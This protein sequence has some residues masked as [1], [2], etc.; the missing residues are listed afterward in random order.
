MDWQ[1]S[2]S[3][4]T[5]VWFRLMTNVVISLAEDSVGSVQQSILGVFCIVTAFLLG[6]YMR[7]HP[8]PDSL[9]KNRRQ[10]TA[11]T[12]APAFAFSSTTPTDKTQVA[13]TAP[14]LPAP[15]AGFT[16]TAP[17]VAKQ[18]AAR[19]LTTNTF[20]P[21]ESTVQAER[22]ID[23]PDF[24]QLAASFKNTALALPEASRIASSP[25]VGSPSGVQTTSG[26]F[27]VRST[28]EKQPIARSPASPTNLPMEN[29]RGQAA[30]VGS[31]P[32][33]ITP[34]QPME[35]H[36]T[37]AYQLAERPTS[38]Q[39]EDFQPHLMTKSSA[40]SRNC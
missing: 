36:S 28:S 6:Q 11:I 31:R 9:E 21:V 25:N 12:P 17:P 20:A 14:R 8:S 23:V 30:F 38:F 29:N 16:A 33:P 22:P 13:K 37:D 5:R 18:T 24:S 4:K 10:Q 7:N 3:S 26:S 2:A 34:P 1:R 15:S 39:K 35:N 40:R 19:P 27:Y 32:E